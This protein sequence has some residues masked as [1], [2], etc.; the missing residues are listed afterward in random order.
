MGGVGGIVETVS[1]LRAEGQ[2]GGIVEML[3]GFIACKRGE[4][5]LVVGLD[6]LVLEIEIAITQRG[7]QGVVPLELAFEVM[8][9]VIEDALSGEGVLSASGPVGVG[10]LSEIEA[11]VAFVGLAFGLLVLCESRDA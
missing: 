6:G 9:L 1:K 10:T 11:E 7:V 3:G 5:N 2:L 4:L 8:D